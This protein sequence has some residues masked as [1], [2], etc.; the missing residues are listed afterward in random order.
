MLFASLR[1]AYKLHGLEI[2]VKWYRCAKRPIFET[3]SIG[4]KNWFS[5]RRKSLW[6][7]IVHQ[8]GRFH[9]PVPCWIPLIVILLVL[10]A[11]PP[12]TTA[13]KCIMVITLNLLLSY[14]KLTELRAHIFYASMPLKVEGVLPLSPDT[15]L[16]VLIFS[17]ITVESDLLNW[18]PLRPILGKLCLESSKC[19]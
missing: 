15:T 18:L 16:I 17:R 10:H 7:A 6:D 11:L 14:K 19:S 13:K 12:R 9:I 4:S 1:I 5:F 2:R 8:R 3:V